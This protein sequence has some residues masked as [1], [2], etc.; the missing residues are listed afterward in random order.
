M[1]MEAVVY[2]SRAISILTTA[3]ATVEIMKDKKI[4]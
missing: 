2:Q 4:L 1:T 3:V